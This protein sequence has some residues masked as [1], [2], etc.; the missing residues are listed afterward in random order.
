MD[1][2]SERNVQFRFQ[3]LA[4]AS[5]AT[6]MGSLPWAAGIEGK[7]RDHLNEYRFPDSVLHGI[8]QMKPQLVTSLGE[9]ASPINFEGF[10]GLLNWTTPVLPCDQLLSARLPRDAI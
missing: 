1:T 7:M 5:F 6:A 3:D 10:D 9:K 8:V 4:N 2:S